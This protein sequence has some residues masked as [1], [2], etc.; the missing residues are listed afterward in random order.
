MKT[1][2][3]MN[4]VR[5]KSSEF[6]VWVAMRQRCSNPRNDKYADYGGRGISVCAAWGV[7]AQFLEDMGPRPAGMSLDR[8]DN[9]GPYEPNNCRWATRQ[10]QCSNQR[11]TV[12]VYI[13]EQRMTFTEAC[14]FVGVNENMARSR[15]RLGWSFGR[16]L[17]MPPG[18]Y[19][20]GPQW[21]A[22]CAARSPKGDAHWTR[23][24]AIEGRAS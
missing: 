14:A 10:Q 6:A 12:A 2:V 20:G 23:K 21:S 19:P 9:N 18:G 17:M 11:R 22:A 8:I 3:L 16:A 7:F 5:R 13:N 4:G 1:H 15:L 24:A